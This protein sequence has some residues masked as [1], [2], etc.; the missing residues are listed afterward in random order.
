M[1]Q[2]WFDKDGQFWIM[3]EEGMIAI[4]KNGEWLT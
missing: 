4:G 3:T 1:C 2:Q